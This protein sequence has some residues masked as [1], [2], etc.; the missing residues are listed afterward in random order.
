[1]YGYYFVLDHVS[2]FK[3]TLRVKICVIWEGIG[4]QINA[5]FHQREKK[6]HLHKAYFQTNVIRILLVLS[7]SLFNLHIFN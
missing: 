5:I 3:E 1:M 6:S 4:I 7:N 2:F